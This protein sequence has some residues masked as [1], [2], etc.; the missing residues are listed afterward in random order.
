MSS[1]VQIGH[2]VQR[3]HAEP[4]NDDLRQ[5]HG[6]L[7][8]RAT[9]RL[10][11]LGL[12]PGRGVTAAQPVGPAQEQ[13]DQPA[14]RFAADA[15]IGTH[16]AVVPDLLVAA[17]Q[18]VLQE[19]ADKLF[20]ADAAGLGFVRLGGRVSVSASNSRCLGSQK[21]ATLQDMQ[22]RGYENQTPR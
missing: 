2:G 9:R 3:Q 11:G 7:A 6:V 20:A 4:G 18:D 15:A 19:P 21:T 8:A 14:H 17:W 22:S 16:P 13:P 1:A 5:R 12:L 10:W